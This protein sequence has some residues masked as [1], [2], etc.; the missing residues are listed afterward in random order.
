MTD[1]GADLSGP[2]LYPDSEHDA[3]DCAAEEAAERADEAL[4]EA[5]FGRT[6][7]VHVD[8]NTGLHMF[9]FND[10]CAA[11]VCT[12]CGL[13]AH[14]NRD[15]RVTQRLERC[16]CGWSLTS[17]GRGRQELEDMGEVIE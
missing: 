14:V 9:E 4:L 15:G 8:P 6:A 2:D 11:H 17:P 1:E 13:H 12:G 7:C 3:A 16:W 5:E 10:H